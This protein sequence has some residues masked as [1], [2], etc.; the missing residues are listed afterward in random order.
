[1]MDLQD[2]RQLLARPVPVDLAAKAFGTHPD[3]LAPAVQEGLIALGDAFRLAR[4]EAEGRLR[5]VRRSRRSQMMVARRGAERAAR[6]F[7]DR[8]RLALALAA[9]R[10]A[11]VASCNALADRLLPY[12]P[13]LADLALRAGRAAFEADPAIALRPARRAVR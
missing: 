8:H 2:A 4:R 3:N 10:A 13:R 1:M 6:A 7:V 5:A 12:A 11:V 9:L